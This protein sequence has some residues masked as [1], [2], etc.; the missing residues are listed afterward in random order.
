MTDETTPV[1][2]TAPA[3]EPAPEV[4]VAQVVETPNAPDVSHVLTANVGV[5]AAQ[6][7][8]PA[9]TASVAPVS[10]T[11]LTTD[12]VITDHE[13]PLST[14]YQFLGQ[15]PPA[16]LPIG[17]GSGVSRKAEDVFAAAGQ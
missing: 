7:F 6:V 5:E 3:V 1:E 10:E 14:K 16:P 12:R 2:A 17:G 11:H 8:G 15:S 4:E 9:R 13:D